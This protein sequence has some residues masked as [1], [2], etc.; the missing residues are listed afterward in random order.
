MTAANLHRL[1]WA[2]EGQRP[3]SLLV[4]LLIVVILSWPFQIAYVL[5]SFDKTQTPLMSYSLSSL[6]MVM[7]R[8]RHVHRRAL[9]I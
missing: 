4:Y 3:F 8:R 6:S 9:R 1:G 2:S 7:G 5:W